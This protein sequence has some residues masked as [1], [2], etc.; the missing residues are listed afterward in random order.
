MGGP[1]DQ[2]SPVNLHELLNP[3]R[4]VATWLPG[5]LTRCGWITLLALGLLTPLFSPAFTLPPPELLTDRQGLPQSFIPS[6][7]QDHQG[8]IWMATRDGLARYDGQQFKVFQPQ[9]TARPSL[10]FAGIRQLT[11]DSRGRLWILSEQSDIDLF[12][13]RTETFVNVSRLAPFRQLLKRYAILSLLL[14]RQDRVWFGLQQKDQ[15]IPAGI[16]CLDVLGRR[17]RRWYFP[18]SSGLSREPVRDLC[19]DQQGRIWIMSL[20]GL[21]QLDEQRGR[22]NAVAQLGQAMKTYGERN[23]NSIYA[24][25]GGE[26]LIG[27]QRGLFALDPTRGTLQHYPLLEDRDITWYNRFAQDS[28]GQVYFAYR[29]HLYRYARGQ[30]PQP[31]D[32]FPTDPGRCLSLLV[33]RSDV[34]WCGTDG[35]GIRKYDLRAHPFVRTPYQRNFLTD[36]LRGWLSADEAERVTGPVSNPYLFRSTVD[37][38]GRLWVNGGTPTFLQWDPTR[39]QSRLISLPGSPFR[40]ETPLATDPGGGVWTLVKG[41]Q[42][43]LY[44]EVGQQWKPTPHRLDK[45][46]TGLVL[47][48]VAD[49]SAFWLATEANGL[50]RLDRRTAQLRHYTQRPADSTSLSSNAL[51]CLSGDPADTN[52]LW[53]GTFGSGLCRFDKRTGISQQLTTR[54]GLPN[55]VIYSAIP[56]AQGYLWMGTNKGLCRMQRTS[57]QMRIYQRADGILADEFNRFHYLQ[58]PGPV[59]APWTGRG[60]VSRS[61]GTAGEKLVMAGL[62]GFTT[63]YPNQ[64]G[65]DRFAPAVEL[66]SLKL[67]NKLVTTDEASPLVTR[68]I[69]AVAHLSLPY[70]QNFV[71]VGFAAL[72]FNRPQAN[73]YRYRLEGLETRWVET[74]QPQ[75]VYTDLRPGQYTLL[76]NAANTSGQWS[77]HVRRLMITIHPPLWATGWAYV[78]YT[79]LGG[80]LIGYGFSAYL[81]RLRVEQTAAWQHKEAQQLREI[82]AM[83]SRFFANITHE[84]R[85]PLTLILTPAQQL[86]STLEDPAQHRW[87]GAIERNA[88]QLLGLIN[89]LMDLSKLD[90]KAMPINESQGELS[91]FVHQCVEGFRGQSQAKGLHLRYKTDVTGLYWFDSGKLEQILANLLSNALKFTSG[92]TT[93]DRPEA[94]QISV[95]LSAT[96]GGVTLI[97]SDTGIGIPADRLPSIFDR[98]YQVTTTASDGQAGSGIGL[99]LVQELVNL[100][101]GQIRVQSQEKEG[102]QTGSGWTRFTVQ[103]PYRPTGVIDS[104]NTPSTPLSSTQAPPL[105]S[106]TTLAGEAPTILVVEDNPELAALIVDSLPSQYRIIRVSNGQEGLTVATEQ[107]PDLVVSDVLMPV[108]DGYT[109]CQTLKTDLRTSHIPVILLTAKSAH[110]SRMQ[111]LAL[112]ADDYLTKPFHVP[113]LQLRVHNLLQQRAR[114]RA[115]V[116]QS[117]L[118]PRA[119]ELPA[120]PVDPFLA[121]VYGLLEAHL[122]EQTYGVDTLAAD[123]AMSRPTLYR[124]CTSVASLATSE[125]IQNYRLKRATELLR[126]GYSSTETAY[127]VGF[128]TPTYFAKRFKELYGVSPSD[129]DTKSQ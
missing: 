104:S 21:Y 22:I 11:I 15:W 19:Q 33:D 6:I 5:C 127:R 74:P 30:P 8:F 47:Q 106:V 48:V 82:D 114:L 59:P 45:G 94:G 69:Q 20:D 41:E 23:I 80:M 63:F 65:D 18:S 73:R 99:A 129:Y 98:F 26:L 7:V 31:V 122:D 77:P 125:L 110:Q 46:R 126:Q 10:S 37:K 93:A 88:H 51:L 38:E 14:D 118:S 68:P 124:K 111:G 101:N 29:Q 71:T 79:L 95:Q 40:G 78:L 60:P 91:E 105:E 62:D 85:T 55:N 76:V 89:Q 24:A 96:E 70:D 115:W 35:L 75:A 109:L 67:N 84:F 123:L 108:M 54:N 52:R 117:L 61:D 90:A 17:F 92:R 116:H 34:L 49:G 119:P 13:P 72:Q 97:V 112:G 43:W 32:Q 100:Q 16:V 113:E 128:N 44:D 103:L 1:A 53:L 56:D 42:F 3:M 2:R 50:F 102:T 58:L 39:R 28:R 120:E 81:K 27:T 4:F 12:D 66:T 36:L 64:L 83:K 86:K 107:L 57:F 9:T 121:K 25:P 87:V